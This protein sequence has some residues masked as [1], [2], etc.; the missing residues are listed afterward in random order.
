MRFPF[1]GVLFPHA[2]TT[3]RLCLVLKN[4]AKYE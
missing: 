1:D 4:F 2:K 3:L